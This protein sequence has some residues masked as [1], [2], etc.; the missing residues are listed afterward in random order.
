MMRGGWS[1]N[2]LKMVV[3]HPTA[4]AA[5]STNTAAIFYGNAMDM[6]VQD[7]VYSKSYSK[8]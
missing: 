2:G 8:N 6:G 1:G 4:A 5:N 7:G 3:L